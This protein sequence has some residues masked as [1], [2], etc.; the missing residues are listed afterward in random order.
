MT[1]VTTT[2]GALARAVRVAQNI[3][4][5]VL[6]LSATDEG[7]CIAG[8][9]PFGVCTFHAIVGMRTGSGPWEPCAVCAASLAALVEADDDQGSRVSFQRGR[10]GVMARCGYDALSLPAKSLPLVESAPITVAAPF[11]GRVEVQ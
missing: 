9:D 5:P 7:L 11:A 4:G 10:T 3:L 2:R 1:D 6:T 8:S